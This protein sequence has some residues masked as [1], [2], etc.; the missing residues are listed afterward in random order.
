MKKE[1][2][3]TTMKI[4]GMMCGMCESHI[5]DTIRKAVP[6][7][8]SVSASRKK[9]EAS[10]ITDEAVDA[11]RLMNAVNATGYSCLSV[12]SAPYKKQGLFRW[13]LE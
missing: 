1:F 10:F 2:I 6:S 7:A 13:K 5:C 11:Q 3:R 4:E 9:K 12:E 8:K